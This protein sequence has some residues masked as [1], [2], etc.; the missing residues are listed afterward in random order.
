MFKSLLAVLVLSVA[1]IGSASATGIYGVFGKLQHKNDAK[2]TSMTQEFNGELRS[3]SE[4][5][6]ND[7]IAAVLAAQVKGANSANDPAT[8]PIVSSTVMHTL[9]CLLVN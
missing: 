6:C 2:F 3:S 7:K 4:T 1:M 5:V 9:Q 8:F